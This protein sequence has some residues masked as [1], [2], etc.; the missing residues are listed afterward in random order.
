AGFVPITKTATIVTNGCPAGVTPPASGVCP[1]G[2]IRY[3]LDFRNIMVGAGLGTEGQLLSAFDYVKA[4]SLIIS[5]AGNATFTN[6]AATNNTAT[7][8]NGLASVMS[9][10]AA[11]YAACSATA[12]SCGVHTDHDAG[13]GTTTFTGN[14]AGSTSWTATIGGASF[15]LVPSGYTLGANQATQGTITFAEVVK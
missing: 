7:Y 14:V 9:G 8:T 13:V 2:T 1:G 15:Q 10:T 3:A 5:D 4:G 11:T 12:N 6:G